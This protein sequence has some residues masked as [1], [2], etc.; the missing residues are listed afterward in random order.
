MQ[1]SHS[2]PVITAAKNDSSPAVSSFVYNG[3]TH[4]LTLVKETNDGV[5]ELSFN[6]SLGASTANPVSCV[7]LIDLTWPQV[8]ELDADTAR[9]LLEEGTDAIYP[10]E[11]S[12][13][14]CAV[15]CKLIDLSEKF[16]AAEQAE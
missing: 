6:L 13:E 14:F 9:D 8:P 12:P 3:N 1:T 2:V 15:I 11:F 4:E 10:A 5:Q 7:E 16:V